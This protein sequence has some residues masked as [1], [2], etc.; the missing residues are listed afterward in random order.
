MKL[1]ST[2]FFLS[3]I[4]LQ[5]ITLAQVTITKTDIQSGLMNAVLVDQHDTL[6]ATYHLG[7]TSDGQTW[8]FSNITYS[9]ISPASYR[10]TIEYYAAAGR[11]GAEHFPTASIC[12]PTIT[13]Q[14]QGPYTFTVTVLMYASAEDDG[15]YMLG[16]VMRQQISPAPN[17]PIPGY[18]ADTTFVAISHPK[19]LGIPL[20]VS[21]NSSVRTWV[22]TIQLPG[23]SLPRY[24]SQT[25][26]PAGSG[27]VK[28]PGGAILSC[29]RVIRDYTYSGAQVDHE[30]EV[31]YFCK[32]GS[33]LKFH[34][35]DDYSTGNTVP[36][37][38]EFTLRVGV[39]SV[40]Q[41]SNKVPE[42]FRLSQNY[43]NPFNPTTTISFD[44]K[45]AEFI[46]LK[47]YNVIGQEVATLVQERMSPGTYTAS[48]DA[49]GLTSGVYIY[50]LTS[51]GS[52][53][54]R[55]MILLK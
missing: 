5:T 1:L 52:V 15:A 9:P 27:T 48:F 46:T 16:Y 22:D 51:G 20:P 24:S 36:I 54:S 41:S 35:A 31:I 7:N 4:L 55:S 21:G 32:D 14:V 8:D 53:Q 28:I 19:D 12:Q 45:N 50:R 49:S 3:I 44:V 38:Y 23:S 13:S 34:V 29:V 37:S 10:D 2:I 47:V 11:Y 33:Q 43:P 6:S 17:P 39:L 26:T 40:K 18:P 30:R 42:N 25:Y